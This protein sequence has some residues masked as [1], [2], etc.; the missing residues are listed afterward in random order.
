MLP[1]LRDTGLE[2]G[3]GGRATCVWPVMQDWPA[4]LNHLAIVF[5]GRMPA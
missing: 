4:A 5:P 2:D 3:V 1:G